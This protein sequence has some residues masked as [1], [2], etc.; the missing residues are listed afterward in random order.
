M[1]NERKRLKF[2]V[3]LERYFTNFHRLLLTNILFAIPSILFA[4]GMYYFN[5]LV[6]D[7]ISIPFALLIILPL[8]P[9]YA[10]VVLV[11]RNI[12][13]GDSGV[14]V[15]YHY[16]KAIKENFLTFLL[17]GFLIYIVTAFGYLAISFYISFLSKSWVFYALLFFC[18]VIALFL[19]YTIFYIPLMSLTFDIRLKYVYKNSFLMSFGEF[20]NNFFATIALAVFLGICFTVTA[21]AGSTT[22]LVIVVAV[23]WV[24]LV[25]ATCTFCY[26]FF[27][28]DGMVSIMRDKEE[29][30][31]N[32]TDTINAK[33]AESRPKV[34]NM[35]E[36]DFSDIDIA[37]LRD[38][39]EYIYHNGRMIKQSTLLRMLKD[40]EGATEVDKHE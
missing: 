25:P 5:V 35:D 6:F 2:E 39:E 24:L 33:M 20:K 32:L 1:E 38:T 12:A 7:G 21:F 14:R 40:R 23:L 27:I 11:T 22:V 9:F 19:L 3:F 36:D 28:Y 16:F 18:L 10:G 34:I 26:V 29:I 30:S 15:C 4:V 8:Y 37:S 31:R 17:H 13:R